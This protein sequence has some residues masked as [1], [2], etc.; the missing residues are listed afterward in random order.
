M[1]TA[2]N[3]NGAKTRI[4]HGTSPDRRSYNMMQVTSDCQQA[5]AHKLDL[6]IG[7]WNVRTLYKISQLKN[8]K[9]EV[10]RTKV[11]LL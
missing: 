6:K 4:H 9:Q 7:M 10:L 8:I 5:T 11:D 1:T 2:N 3:V